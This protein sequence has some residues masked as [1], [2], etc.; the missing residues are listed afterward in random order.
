MIQYFQVISRGVFLLAG[1]LLLIAPLHAQVTTGSI[2]GRVTDSQDR[3]VAGATVTVTNP[4]TH[5]N[6]SSITDDSGSYSITQLPA[7]KYD[8]SVEAPNFK[9]SIAQNFELNVGANATQGFKLEPGEVTATV[10]VTAEQL[11]VET[12]SSEI[13]KNITPA[14]VQNLPLLNRTFA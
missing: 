13:G 12:T 4:A 7:G 2:S 6:R 10:Q 3:S 14:E 1:T 11:G 9:K 5:T 8:I